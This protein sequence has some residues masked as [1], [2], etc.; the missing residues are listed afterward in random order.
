MSDWSMQAH[1]QWQSG[2][3][4]DALKSDKYEDE[5]ED[6]QANANVCLQSCNGT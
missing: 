5:K 1:S 6:I 4:P 3:I 2:A